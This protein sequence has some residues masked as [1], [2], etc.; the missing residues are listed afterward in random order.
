MTRSSSTRNGAARRDLSQLLALAP[1]AAHRVVDD[2]V[3]TVP[4]DE[5]ARGDLLIVRPGEVVPVDGVVVSDTVTVDEST[6]TGEPLPVER[7]RGDVVRSGAINAGAAVRIEAVATASSSAYASIVRLV[8]DAGAGRASFVRLAD[9]YALFFIPSTLALAGAA[10]IASGDAVRALA[11]LVVATPCPLV[12]AAPVAIVSGIARAARDGV[13]VKDGAALEALAQ[14]E[15]VL[16]D[17][18]GTLTVGRPTVTGV[19]VAPGADATTVLG[20]AAAVEQASPHV[21][22]AAVVGEARARS[23]PLG[24]PEEVVEEPGAGVRGRV[25]GHDVV[26]GSQRTVLAGP[27]PSWVQAALRR[28]G[29]ESC[30]TVFVA[31]DGSPA[32]VL[33]VTDELRLDTAPALRALRR[34]GVSRMAMVTGDQL[35]VA[36]P[37]GLALGLDAVYADQ[38]PEEKVAVVI[39]ETASARTLMVGDGV[40]DAPA[41]AAADL[42]VAMGARGA[43]ASSDVASVVVI[44]DRLDHVAIGMRVAQRSQRIA[45]E[46]VLAGMGMSIVA[47]VVAALGALPPVAGA[48]LQ[49]VIDVLAIANALRASAR[50]AW[51]KRVA[52]VPDAWGAQLGGE[53][54]R[55][56]PLLDELRTTADELDSLDPDVAAARVRSLVM[57]INRDVLEHERIDE[58]TIYPA[59]ARQLET[60]DP[61]AAMSRT[62]REIFQLA[63]Q[64]DRLV[65]DIGEGGLVA[66]DRD[67]ARRILYVLGALLALHFAEEEE[68]LASLT[69]S[70]VPG[71]GAA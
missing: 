29:R 22:A 55:M 38:S 66:A 36:E 33:L 13:I 5:V 42:G 53:H 19:V 30:S 68:L 10:W 61:L 47:M 4:I 12:L 2:A 3:T 49:E 34:A 48:V 32:A 14:S 24:A 63:G 54:L 9:R 56:R 26:V 50:P 28:A 69:V 52:A 23:L 60:D 67:E 65:A 44:I 21:L 8:E 59:V 70:R 11:V 16:F 51:D 41:L 58:S 17:K 57:R 25:E 45:R 37:I 20:L 71:R 39:A 7:V 15:T 18:T 64:L 27:P 1:T 31:V 40:N 6:L 46:S 62:H 43:T 35:R